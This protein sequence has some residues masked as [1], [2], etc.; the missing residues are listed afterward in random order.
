MNKPSAAYDRALL[1]ST[2]H[3]ASQKTFSGKFLRPHK[4]FL[5]D[6]IQRRRIKSALDYGAG[7][8]AQYTW[9][10][11]ED[12]K[13]LEQAFGFEVAK[14][15]PAYPPF[16]AEPVGAFDLVICTHTLGSIPVQDLDWVIARLYSLATKAVYIAEKI[17]PVK[18]TVFSRPD[19]HPIGWTPEQWMERITPFA[20][21]RGGIETHV[22]FRTRD[23]ENGV[24]IARYIL[25]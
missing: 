18:K 22:S 6:L 2:R 3:H 16:A 24:Q 8:G 13:T 5:L 19:E 1:E 10:D 4:P 25:P 7:K 12:G 23:E 20:R 9:V 21:A 11:P 15:D 14:F 17:G